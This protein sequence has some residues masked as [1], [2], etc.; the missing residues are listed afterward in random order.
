MTLTRVWIPSPNYSSRNANVRL[1]V[2][3]SSEGARTYQSLGN[4]FANPSSQVSSHVGID[5]T[6]NTVGEYVRRDMKAW[7]AA[8][9]NPVA[10]QAELCTPSGASATWST[11][12]WNSHPVMLANLAQWIREEAAAF[13]IPIVRLSPSQ[14]QTDGRGVCQHLDLGGWGGGHVDCGPGFPIDQVIA[15]AAGT[16]PPIPPTP[17][18]PPTALGDDMPITVNRTDGFID[19]YTISPDGTVNFLC[20]DPAGNLNA[21]QKVPGTYRAMLSAGQTSDRGR[22]FYGVGG[23]GWA[24]RATQPVGGQWQGP[25]RQPN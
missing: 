9:A 14:A 12:V 25:G 6:P 10:V 15:D 24:W 2:I 7:T 1:I 21:S 11:A 4:F 13:N 19:S 3:H 16:T 5:D 17:T 22:Y 23:D 8:N 18:P 20:T